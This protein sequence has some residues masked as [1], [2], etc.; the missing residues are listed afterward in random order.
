MVSNTSGNDD[1]ANFAK[2]Q[3]WGFLVQ[4]HYN[5][6]MHDASDTCMLIST[7]TWFLDS[8]ASKHIS[9]CKSLFTFLTDALKGGSVTCANYASFVA[10]GIG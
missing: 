2:D 3:S 7:S 4:C 6:S 1:H 5:P 10:K 9:S 8:G